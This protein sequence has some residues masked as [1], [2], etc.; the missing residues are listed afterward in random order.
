[1]TARPRD[2][3][4]QKTYNVD[5][6]M[7][8]ELLHH[9][10]AALV[11]ARFK[12]VVNSAW[13]RDRVMEDKYWA[14]P[15]KLQLSFPRYKNV[16]ANANYERVKLPTWAW[17]DATLSHELAHAYIFRRYGMLYG[18]PHQARLASDVYGVP[19]GTLFA[20][21]GPEFVRAHIEILRLLAG[22][23]AASRLMDLYRKE[24]CKIAGLH[25]VRSIRD[26]VIAAQTRKAAMS[27]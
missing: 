3:Q 4:R 14:A 10:D 12:K 7:R 2:S 5:H 9:K 26:A 21:H 15:L 24:G 27:L 25:V 17:D 22:S 20:W 16:S 1:M 13:W 23:T 11:M 19:K 18:M 8:K 6:A